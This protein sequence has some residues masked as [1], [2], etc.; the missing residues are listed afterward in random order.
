MT[1]QSGNQNPFSITKANDFSDQEILRFWVDTPTTDEDSTTLIRPRSPMPI[2]VLG[3][4]GSG[5]TH[6]MRYHSF[7][8]QRLRLGKAGIALQDGVRS[9]GYIGIYLRCGGLNAGRFSGK[10]QTDDIW[11]GVFAY[12]VELWLAHHVLQVAQTFSEEGSNSSEEELLVRRVL[13]L[14]DSQPDLGTL[15]ILS[16]IEFVEE[17]RKRLDFQINNCVITGTLDIAF[18]A[19]RGRLVFGIPKLLAEHFDYLREVTFIYEIDELENLSAAQQRLINSFVRDRELPTTFRIG[20]RLYGVKTYRTDADQ[21]ENIAE[22]EFERVYLDEE[23][24]RS[25]TTY[26]RFARQVLEK[27]LLE[28]TPNIGIDSQRLEEA[29]AHQDERWNSDIYLTMV[30]NQPSKERLYFKRFATKLSRA[31]VENIKEV[32]ERLSVHKYPLL[33][34]ANILLFLRRI[35]FEDDPILLADTIQEQW[36]NFVSG[37]DDRALARRL[38]SIMEHYHGD[39]VAQLRR[40]MGQK[41]YYFGLKTFV[42]MS[43]G[44]PRALLTILRTVFDWAIYKGEDFG[45]EGGISLDSQYRGV[46]EASEWFFN[47][48]RK[49]GGDGIAIQSA[50]DRLAQVFRVNRFSDL[51]VECSLNSFS[52]SQHG[53][54]DEARRILRLCEE[55]SFLN[56]VAGGQKHKNTMEVQLKF[57]LHPMLCPRWQLP[58]GRRGAMELQPD[59]ANAI[60][61]VGSQALFLEKL[62]QIQRKRRF[63]LRK[64]EGNLL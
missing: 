48:M 4:K 19:T 44:L 7:P 46:N 49:T 13:S 5:K 54:T 10:R 12:Y 41:Q 62:R 55:R 21:E 2:F 51:P 64:K 47:S 31:G 37:G 9:E 36:Q 26:A 32:V 52:V 29:F 34:K 6:L 28:V 45:T 60:F 11:E 22:S 58:I 35:R 17:E 1:L 27:R 18:S 20:A 50:T 61:E 14:F 15:K 8:L 16:L 42:A 33:E 3:A 43:G 30:Q 23:L 59:F 56:R 57:Q 63:T 39:L 40:D 53:L 25:R 38:S 24:R